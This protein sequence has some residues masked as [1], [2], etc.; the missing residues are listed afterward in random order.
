[1]FTLRSCLESAAE[2]VLPH[3][4]ASLALGSVDLRST[5]EWTGR[6]GSGLEQHRQ[7]GESSHLARA[8]NCTFSRPATTFAGPNDRREVR[9]G[10]A[11]IRLGKEQG[12]DAIARLPD[13]PEEIDGGSGGFSRVFPATRADMV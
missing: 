1:M 4:L 7:E 6:D 9:R 3:R 8:F 2:L 5:V 11:A 13:S 12:R 10:Q